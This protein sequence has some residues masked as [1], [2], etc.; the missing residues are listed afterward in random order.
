MEGKLW[1]SFFT[2]YAGAMAFTMIG[3]PFLGLYIGLGVF[4]GLH[5]SK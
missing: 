3:N 5:K 2:A 4:L 1:S